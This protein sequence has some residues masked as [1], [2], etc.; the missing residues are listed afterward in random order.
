MTIADTIFDTIN[1]NWGNGGYAGTTPAIDTTETQTDSDVVTTDV[2][3]VRHY[4]LRER[5]EQLNDKYVNRH[6][7]IDVYISSK[8]DNAQLKLVYDEVEYL[9][10]NTTMTGLQLEKIDKDWSVAM[11]EQGRHSVILRVYVVALLSDGAVTSAAGVTASMQAL[12]MYTSANAAWQPCTLE[13]WNPTAKGVVSNIGE[14]ENVDNTAIFITYRCPLVPLKGTLKLYIAATKIHV[15]NA[16]ATNYI[17]NTYLE[18]LATTIGKTTIDTDATDKNSAGAKTDT[19]A[20]AYDCSSYAVIQ[21]RLQTVNAD[22]LALSINSVEVQCY[23][24]T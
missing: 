4:S 17:T 6:Y 21:I 3:E 11:W 10:R 7:T 24:D 2:V 14:V 16:N 23:Y 13:G 15:N 8:T 18:G 1:D 5:G 19:F 9:L 22:A 20:S 12:L